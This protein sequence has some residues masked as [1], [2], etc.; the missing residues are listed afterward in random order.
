MLDNVAATAA[1][2]LTSVLD[3][4]T[5][6]FWADPRDRLQDTLGFSG[7]S[8]RTFRIRKLARDHVAD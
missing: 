1:N 2:N 8:A 6:A 4:L 3:R 5:V 7:T